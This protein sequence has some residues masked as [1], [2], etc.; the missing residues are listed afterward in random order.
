MWPFRK[1]SKRIPLHPNASNEVFVLPWEEV[2]VVCQDIGLEQVEPGTRVFRTADKTRRAYVFKRDDGTY[3]AAYEMLVAFDEDD[4]RYGTP[5]HP[6]YWVSYES[7]TSIYDSIESATQAIQEH[8]DFR[9]VPAG[10]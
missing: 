10:E 3:R 2:V 8:P 7:W 5:E 4:L 9:R 1:K 6:G